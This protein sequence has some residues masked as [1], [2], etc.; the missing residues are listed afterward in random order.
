MSWAD[1]RSLSLRVVTCVAM[2][3]LRLADSL[4]GGSR[5]LIMAGVSTMLSHKLAE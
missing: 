5:V 1:T 2:H 3:L 4:D